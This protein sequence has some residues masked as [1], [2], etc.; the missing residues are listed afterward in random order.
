M[1][2]NIYITSSIKVFHAHIY[3][4]QTSRE[5]AARIREDLGKQFEVKLGRWHEQPI[6]P[7]PKSMYQ[8]AFTPD[9][10]GAIVPWLMLNHQGL[11][12][13]IHPET[14]NDVKDHSDNALWLGEKL[15]LNLEFLR[16]IQ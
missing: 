6:G 16:Q 15:T 5:I 8:V 12:I 14:G 4:D 7:H 3:F 1:T 10:F 9:H 11:D 13:L 2:D